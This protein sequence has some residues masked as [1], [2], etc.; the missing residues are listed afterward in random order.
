MLGLRH[1]FPGF[2]AAESAPCPDSCQAS[3][4]SADTV[5]RFTLV[6][7]LYWVPSRGSQRQDISSQRYL[8]CVNGNRKLALARFP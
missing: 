4:S 1:G 6:A 7:L 5:Q 8:I 3:D 2:V